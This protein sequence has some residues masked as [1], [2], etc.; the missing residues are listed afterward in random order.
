MQQNEYGGWVKTVEKFRLSHKAKVLPQFRGWQ[1]NKQLY[2]VLELTQVDLEMVC[3]LVKMYNSRILHDPNDFTEEMWSVKKN[4]C[5]RDISS[6]QQISQFTSW[7]WNSFIYIYTI[8]SLLFVPIIRDY[9]WLSY[10]I[11]AL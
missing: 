11:I 9:T 1:Y 6:V 8:S 3:D 4:M 5:L 10:V 2:S 7:H